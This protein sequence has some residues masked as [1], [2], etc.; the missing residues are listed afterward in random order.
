MA[1][2]QYFMYEQQKRQRKIKNNKHAVVTPLTTQKLFCLSIYPSPNPRPSTQ[3]L[4]TILV[5]IIF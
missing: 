3:L 1:F 4:G 2:V 5:S